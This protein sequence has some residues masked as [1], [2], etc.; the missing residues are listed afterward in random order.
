MSL[1]I[2][3]PFALQNRAL[4][5]GRKG[6]KAA[7]KRGRRGVGSKAGKMGKRTGENRSKK[8]QKFPKDPKKSQKYA[9]NLIG[10]G[11][12]GLEDVRETEAEKQN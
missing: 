3:V 8:R 9:S 7:E 12:F 11:A 5:R 6:R 4:S 10:R 1:P 2:S